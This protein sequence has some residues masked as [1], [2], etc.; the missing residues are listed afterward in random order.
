MLSAAEAKCLADLDSR[1]VML[2]KIAG[3][4]KGEMS[5]AAAALFVSAQSQ[6]LSLLEAYKAKLPAEE[7]PAEAE[8]AR[9]PRR[10]PQPRRRRPKPK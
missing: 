3:L 4:L 10:K 8:A 1:E 6:F 5:R 2:S 9:Q 7:V